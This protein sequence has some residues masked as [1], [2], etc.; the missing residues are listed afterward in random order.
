ME[1]IPESIQIHE[2]VFALLR[3]GAMI[4]ELVDNLVDAL[5][6]DAYPGE[7]KG[8]VVVEMVRGTIAMALRSLDE[9]DVQRCR[10]VIELASDGLIEHLRVACELSARMHGGAKPIG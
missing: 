2:F 4:C 6:D 10:E 8:G 1:P 5:P 3:T 7:E 9:A